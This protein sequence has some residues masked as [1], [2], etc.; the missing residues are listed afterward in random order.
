MTWK[1]IKNIINN[2]DGSELES[3]AKFL[4]NGNT[5]VTISLEKTAEEHNSSTL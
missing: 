2:M 3:E 4:K 5:L 1:E